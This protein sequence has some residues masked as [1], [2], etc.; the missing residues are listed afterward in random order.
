MGSF[1]DYAEK[2]TLDHLLGKT[3]FP[4]PTA[5]IAL[6]TA[7]PTDAGTGMAEP[8]GG[9]YARKATTGTDWNA[10]TG[11]SPA[12]STNATALSFP[13]A[14]ADWGTITHFAIFDA[15]TDG[16]M[17]VHGALTD[18]RDVLSGDTVSFQAGALTVT[19]D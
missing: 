10:A 15:A 8:S 19:Q 13:Q 5:Y 3:A 1:S 9:S 14:T 2:K 7:D 12:T 16:N 18:G 11:A 17:L 4:M 6:S